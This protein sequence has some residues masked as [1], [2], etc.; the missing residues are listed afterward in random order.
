[1]ATLL[2]LTDFTPAADQALRYAT[3]LAASLEARLLL[4][5]VEPTGLLNPNA[6]T[7]KNPERSEPEIQALLDQR[8]AR[9]ERSGVGCGS[10][11]TSGSI[12]EAV[13]TAV[14]RHS[15]LLAIA[16]KPNTEETPDELVESAA[17]S[18]LRDAPCPVLIVPQ[19]YAHAQVPARVLVAA[20]H[21]AVTFGG[22]AAAA[23]TLLRHWQPAVTVTHVSTSAPDATT[24]PDLAFPQLLLGG[25]T[26]VQ[27]RHD[28]HPEVEQGILAARAAVHADWVVLIARHHS[29]LSLMFNNSVTARVIFHSSVP[30]LVVSEA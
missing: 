4:L 14:R 1:M 3:V 12:A 19:A 20:D 24:A 13:A 29:R 9:A 21:E 30:V 10:E 5:H 7:G 8:C 27:L 25:V 11:M 18:L 6:F 28:T 16:G 2:V 23:N 26:S 15:A 22:S 17:L